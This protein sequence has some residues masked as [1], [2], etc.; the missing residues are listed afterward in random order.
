MRPAKHSTTAPWSKM[1]ARDRG[2]LMYK[3]ADLIEEEADEL[4]ALETLD[5]GKPI[6]RF[7][8]RPIFRW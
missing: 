7:A 5:N 1:D 2:A 8:R 4:A 6:T 3:L